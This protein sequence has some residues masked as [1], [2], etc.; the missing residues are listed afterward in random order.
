MKL[1]NV[2]KRHRI[3]FVLPLLVVIVF[4]A[5]AAYVLSRPVIGTG[6]YQP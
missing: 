3:V 4:I 1:M 6:I 5:F 2:L